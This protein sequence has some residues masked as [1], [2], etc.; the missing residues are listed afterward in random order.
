VPA[1]ASLFISKKDP[2]MKV[3]TDTPQSKKIT[4]L[5][6]RPSLVLG[7]FIFIAGCSVWVAEGLD[8]LTQ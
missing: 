5:G 8:L 2:D 4:C 1:Q 6:S 7:L 3:L